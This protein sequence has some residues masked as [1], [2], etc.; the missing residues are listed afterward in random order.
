M[1]LVRLSA[2]TFPHLHDSPTLQLSN[3]LLYRIKLSLPPPAPPNPSAAAS[4]VPGKPDWF[5]GQFFPLPCPGLYISCGK[6]APLHYNQAAYF[7]NCS[8]E[9]LILACIQTAGHRGSTDLT[10]LTLWNHTAHD[11]Q[12][13]TVAPSVFVWVWFSVYLLLSGAIQKR[14][15]S[16]FTW[17]SLSGAERGFGC[18]DPDLC[19]PPLPVPF[20]RLRLPHLLCWTS[21]QPRTISHLTFNELYNQS[22]A[23][24]NSAQRNRGRKMIGTLWDTDRHSRENSS[25]SRQ[26]VH[27][28]LVYRRKKHQIL[29][30]KIS[31]HCGAS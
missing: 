10:A 16:A 18:D 9:F 19:P 31:N 24:I 11:K 23:A 7:A 20:H 25:G 15:L 12:E 3:S 22:K 28:C 8:P 1:L 14:T 5:T 4:H 29:K 21:A 17:Q 27:S 2:Q 13:R 6:G 30:I 26:V